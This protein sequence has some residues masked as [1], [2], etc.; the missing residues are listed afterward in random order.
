MISSW[1]GFCDIEKYARSLSWK[2]KSVLEMSDICYRSIKRAKRN[3]HHV[4]DLLIEKLADSL[5]MGAMQFQ[6][7]TKDM[8]LSGV[9]LTREHLEN[10]ISFFLA[11]RNTY[12]FRKTIS[13]D[14]FI[15][16]L[17]S[18]GIRWILEIRKTWALEAINKKKYD[19]LETLKITRIRRHINLTKT[20][21]IEHLSCTDEFPTYILK[22]IPKH[23][24]IDIITSPSLLKDRFDIWSSASEQLGRRDSCCLENSSHRE[25]DSPMIRV[26]SWQT[27]DANPKDY[28]SF[29]ILIID[30]VDLWPQKMIQYISALKCSYVF[31][32]VWMNGSIHA[33]NRIQYVK[34]WN[35]QKQK[36]QLSIIRLDSSNRNN[37]A[38]LNTRLYLNEKDSKACIADSSW[39]GRIVDSAYVAATRQPNLFIARRIALMNALE[40]VYQKDPNKI[41]WTDQL[42]TCFIRCLLMSLIEDNVSNDVLLKFLHAESGRICKNCLSWLGKCQN[43]NRHEC[44]I[45]D[46]NVLRKTLRESRCEELTQHNLTRSFQNH[47]TLTTYMSDFANRCDLDTQKNSIYALSIALSNLSSFARYD[48]TMDEGCFQQACKQRKGVT[49]WLTTATSLQSRIVMHGAEWYQKTPYLVSQTPFKIEPLEYLPTTNL[50]AFRNIER[51]VKRIS[52]YF[53]EV[54]SVIGVAIRSYIAY[55]LTIAASMSTVWRWSFHNEISAVYISPAFLRSS[56]LLSR[57]RH[58]RRIW[59]STQFI[60]QSHPSAPWNGL[61][62]TF[63]NAYESSSCK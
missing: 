57:L 21:I 20:C 23:R 27:L 13:L 39:F 61:L 44:H 51:H 17:S 60:F 10:Q 14:A 3:E 15:D 32:G 47:E 36:R 45:N 1:P 62:D 54:W 12:Q 16:F 53:G 6:E 18:K 7:T 4:V 59:P 2:R 63:M 43:Y 8:R 46:V 56:Q 35:P 31:A 30:E 58:M 52:S 41:E 38:R 26:S 50:I 37:R 34:C 11:R 33:A 42:M 29:D 19:T 9:T 48:D 55:D 49:L 28:K 22:N 40:Y 25:K 24:G 5:V